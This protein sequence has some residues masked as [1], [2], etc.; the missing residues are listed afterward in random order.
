[1]PPPQRSIILFSSS[2]SSPFRLLCHFYIAT[3]G[4]LCWLLVNFICHF[5]WTAPLSLSLLPVICL[6]SERDRVPISIDPTVINLFINKRVYIKR[7]GFT[8][9]VTVRWQPVCVIL[10]FNFFLYR[11]RNRIEIYV[12]RWNHAETMTESLV[13]WKKWT[14][15]ECCAILFFTTQKRPVCFAAARNKKKMSFCQKRIHKKGNERI[16]GKRKWSDQEYCNCRESKEVNRTARPAAFPLRLIVHYSI[17]I[18]YICPSS[19]SK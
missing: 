19:K 10:L 3:N 8:F 12:W 13:V 16:N 17:H 15:R 6:V 5:K 11:R 7:G 4:G 14:G 2:S 18:L 9:S 1:M